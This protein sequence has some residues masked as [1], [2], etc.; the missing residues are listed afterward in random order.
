MKRISIVVV[1]LGMALSLGMNANPSLSQASSGYDMVAAVNDFRAA[2]GLPALQTD[3]IL[4]S[5]A[6]AQSEYQA[7]IGTVTHTGPGGTSPK[8]RAYAAGFGGGA[9]IFLS[10][11]IAGGLNLSIQTA[12]YQYWQDATHL[13][14][15]LNPAAVYIGAGVAKAGDY[16]YYTVDAGYYSGAPSPGTSSNV[17][18][19]SNTGPTAVAYDPFV[20]VTPR[21]DGAIIHTVGYGQSLIGIAKTYGVELNEIFQLNG[22][23]MDSIIY[24]GEEIIIRAGS[25]PTLTASPTR[26]LPTATPSLTAT[27]FTPTPRG[28][29]TQNPTASSTPTTTPMPISAE[30]ERLTTGVVVMAL[31]IFLAVVLSGLL[32]KETEDS[33]T[34]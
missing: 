26:T 23:T 18:G 21:E 13:S 6:Q 30:R 9:T 29:F 31:V 24:P 16:V 19:G 27:R 28:T 17:P 3:P 20:V 8:D 15:M 7:S 33:E 34:N 22:L 2:N 32:G 5:I 10:E 12:I 25:T 11:N 1:L 14:T 4:M